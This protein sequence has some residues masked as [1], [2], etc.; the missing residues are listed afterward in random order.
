MYKIFKNVVLIAIFICYVFCWR[1]A[2][3][4]A[5]EINS[6]Y[7][8][9]TAV[10]DLLADYDTS[11]VLRKG[12]TITVYLIHDIKSEESLE[13]DR[14]LNGDTIYDD[15][16]QI[17]LVPRYARIHCWYKILNENDRVKVTITVSDIELDR[18]HNLSV[19][20]SN[21]PFCTTN[22]ERKALRNES[23]SSIDSRNR[24]TEELI[25]LK[26]QLFVSPVM[27]SELILGVESNDRISGHGDIVF[28]ENASGNR[29]VVIKAGYVIYLYVRKDIL[30][31]GPYIDW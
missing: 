17:P 16:G 4:I 21:P 8:A 22:G 29:T 28:S 9:V 13:G 5:Y 23:L 27:S 24:S 25:Q 26:E 14:I 20:F 1:I 15:S 7:R 10:G 12:R 6:M 11:L 31:S 2:P 30:F 3:V 18:R 19:R